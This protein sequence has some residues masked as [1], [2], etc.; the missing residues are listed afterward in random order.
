MDP[1]EALDVVAKDETLA[2]KDEAVAVVK[3]T[4]RA[5]LPLLQHDPGAL[6]HHLPAALR[7]R[8]AMA[9]PFIGAL[10]VVVGPPAMALPAISMKR[11][12]NLR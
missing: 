5:D 6:F 1:V 10:T 8:S 2:A 4:T 7:L 3:D 9:R 11:L 12:V